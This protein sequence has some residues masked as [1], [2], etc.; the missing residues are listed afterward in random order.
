MTQQTLS[1]VRRIVLALS[2]AALGLGTGCWT[3]ELKD[4]EIGC[5]LDANVNAKCP[6]RPPVDA[7]LASPADASVA[8]D[9]APPGIDSS[10]GGATAID[11]GND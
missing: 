9:T 8:P 3:P 1:S 4:A 10:G 2:F 5:G 6:N 7:A 11:S